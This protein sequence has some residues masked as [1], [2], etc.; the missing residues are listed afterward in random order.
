MYHFPFF[1]SYV[2]NVITARTFIIESYTKMFVWV[3]LFY[4]YVVHKYS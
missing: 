1:T 4:L 2:A 3:N